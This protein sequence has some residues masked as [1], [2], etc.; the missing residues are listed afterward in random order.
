MVKKSRETLAVLL[1]GNKLK[2]IILHYK[3][4]TIRATY[5]Y[6]FLKLFYLSFRYGDGIFYFGNMAKTL[7]STFNTQ[8]ELDQ[9]SQPLYCCAAN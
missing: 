7:T 5:N 1:N 4:V 8:Y 3:T 2:Q 9:V 6:F